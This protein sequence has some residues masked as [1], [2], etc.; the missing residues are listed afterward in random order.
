MRVNPFR[1]VYEKLNSDTLSADA[2]AMPLLI[3][4]ELTNACNFDCLFCYTGAKAHH[5]PLGFMSDE[6]Y[7]HI[8]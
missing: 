1:A 8:L 3:D 6:M 2:L 5:R 7:H 4:I